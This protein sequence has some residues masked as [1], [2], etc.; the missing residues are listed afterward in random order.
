[1]NRDR[2]R[3]AIISPYALG[4]PGGV[5]SHVARLAASLAGRG[6]AVLIASPDPSQA[7]GV[8]GS[9][10]ET[11]R[12]SPPVRRDDVRIPGG[13][14]DTSIDDV[15]TTESEFGHVR[16]AG[17]GRHLAVSFN[18]AVAPVGVTPSAWRRLRTIVDDWAPDVVHV[19]EPAVP[20][21]GWA[22]LHCDSAPIVATFHAYSERQRAYRLASTIVNR[23]LRNLSGYIAVSPA[24][25]A[26]HAGALGLEVE[27]F[28][29]I[30]NGVDVAAFS[31][32]PSAPPT[33]RR[34]AGAEPQIL[35]VG[36]LDQRKGLSVL[37]EAFGLLRQRRSV[38]LVVVGDGPDRREAHDRIQPADREAVE[39]LGRI[40]NDLLASSYQQ[41]SVYVAPSLGGESFGIVL[42]EAMA[43]GV[44]VV[45]S[46]IPGYRAVLG[47]GE[48]GCLVQPGDPEALAMAIAHMLDDAQ[49]AGRMAARARIHADGFDWAIVA[50]R[51]R[52]RYLA[53]V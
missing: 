41:S 42:L 51:V 50:E 24:A 43:A 26:Y 5:Q 15:S 29:I 25:A 27:R 14:A 10:I 12:G 38:R 49:A 36:R 48:F 7:S 9:G 46:D 8:Q 23:W 47:D 16:S 4:V 18:G 33:D 31:P 45:A 52:E 44:P 39:F 35:F 3:V 30:P 6:D 53:A 19:H 1:M 34:L 20:L 40:D 37:I 2:L 28:D 17:T 21:V 32:P 11:S 13:V 22:A